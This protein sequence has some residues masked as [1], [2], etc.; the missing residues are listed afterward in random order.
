[1]DDLLRQVLAETRLLSQ[2]DESLE[3]ERYVQ[4]VD[5]RETLTSKIADQEIVSVADK[6]MIKEILN[7]DSVILGI[8]QELKLEALEGL[9]KVQS[10]KKQKAAYDNAGDHESFMF[11]Q[12]K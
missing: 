8:M 6:E 5:L 11:D 12:R 1:M 3:Y 10:F 7:Y 4:L 9:K 2:R